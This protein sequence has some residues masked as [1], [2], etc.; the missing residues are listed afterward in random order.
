MGHSIGNKYASD[1]I[2]RHSHKKQVN[3][4][5]CGKVSNGGENELRLMAGRGIYRYGIVDR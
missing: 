2:F 1:E 3:S 4:I 5:Y